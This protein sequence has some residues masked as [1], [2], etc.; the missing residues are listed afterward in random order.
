MT[1]TELERL[2]DQPETDAQTLRDMQSHAAQCTHCR[3]LMEL[4]NL[5]RDEDVPEKAAA[6]WRA[7]VRT[8]QA[9]TRIS[10]PK[11]MFWRY[12]APVCA[13]AAVLVFAVALRKPITENKQLVQP[14]AQ[15][16]EISAATPAAIMYASETAAPT[17][18]P[19]AT[20]NS[21]PAQNA[22]VL[23]DVPRESREALAFMPSMEDTGAAEIAIDSEEADN[24]IPFPLGL[25]RED[26][27]AEPEDEAE[28]VF[29]ADEAVPMMKAEKAMAAG[30]PVMLH[31]AANRPQEAAAAVRAALGL[32]AEELTAGENGGIEFYVTVSVQQWPA[33][34]S[35]LESAGLEQLPDS[36]DIPW[37]G[38]HAAE[39]SLRIDQKEK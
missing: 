37:D 7:A 1:C 14:V 12:L 21:E 13:A 22:M 33:F 32:D 8:E 35:A 17:R 16:T 6:R 11:H 9:R 2:L 28:D 31:W 36:D 30:V 38:D 29:F 25:D 15:K 19:Q 4:R 3:M 5:D 39:F 23:S 34:L 27:A 24:S 10:R 26:Q 18:M 20:A